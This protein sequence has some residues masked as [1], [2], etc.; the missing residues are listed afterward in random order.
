MIQDHWVHTGGKGWGVRW[1][2]FRK[3]GH[4]Q[5]GSDHVTEQSL[6]WQAGESALYSGGKGES[7]KIS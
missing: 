5:R 2:W 4:G 3:D 7:A 1:G 6:E